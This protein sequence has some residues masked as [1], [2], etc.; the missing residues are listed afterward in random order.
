MNDSDSRGEFH[1]AFSFAGTKVTFYRNREAELLK[2]FG[3]DTDL[4]SCKDV[5]NLMSHMGLPQYVDDEWR[6]FLDSSKKS[7]K[8]VLLHNGN[9]HASIPLGH[10][11]RLREKYEAI[12][13]AL[14]KI[15]YEEH[16]WPICVDL[17]MVSI[18]LGQQGG[19]T[20][21]PCF[22]CLWDSR[23]DGEHWTRTSW[24]SRELIVGEHNVIKKSLVPTDKIILPPLHIKL[25]LVK[26]FIKA[27][28]KNGTCFTEIVRKLPAVSIQKL[29]AGVL[30]GPQIRQLINDPRF[31]DSMDERER[32]AWQAF[33]LVVKNFLGNNKAENYVELVQNMLVSFRALGCRMSIKLHY[34]HSH[35]DWFP[36]NL[37]AMSDEQ[38]ERFHQDL[39]IME[40]RYQGR[41]DVHMMADYCWTLMRDHP[42]REH[43]RQSLTRQFLGNKN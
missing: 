5:P 11:T 4:V 34:L 28:D 21:F 29:R 35:L 20:K 26:Q 15:K 16:R 33:V 18:L 13:F 41:W 40:E 6:L 2:Y 30:D 14:E 7:L 25:G 8:C 17:K 31:V 32:N 24:P 42:R 38:G 19:Y 36:A 22:L 10:S 12:A 27:L 39:A 37:G 1:R 23:A 3:T 9:E 43:S